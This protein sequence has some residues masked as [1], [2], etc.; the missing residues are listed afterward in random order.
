MAH[1]RQS[2][3]AGWVRGRFT[4]S[5]GADSSWEH[6]PGRI[7]QG[8]S[9]PE[10]GTRG[11]MPGKPGMSQKGTEDNERLQCTLLLFAF[12]PQ[13]LCSLPEQT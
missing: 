4:A 6:L 5:V 12:H 8:L 11:A 1:G 10:E 13:P 7:C 9:D 2:L 3:E